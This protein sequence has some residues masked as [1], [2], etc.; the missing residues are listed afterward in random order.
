MLKGAQQPRGGGE[1]GGGV[2]EAQLGKERWREGTLAKIL[3]GAPY[4]TRFP[5]LKEYQLLPNASYSDSCSDRCQHR[6]G[7][8]ECF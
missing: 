3:M 8:H 4:L 2:A 1:V 6:V 5:R 7:A